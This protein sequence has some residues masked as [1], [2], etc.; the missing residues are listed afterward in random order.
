MRI[1]PLLLALTLSLA[2]CGGGGSDP[3]A[4]SEQ[5]EQALGSG[6]YAEA[7]KH[8]EGA[9]AALGG[10]SSGDQ[11][12]RA[13]LGLIEANAFIAPERARDDFLDLARTSQDIGPADYAR[14]GGRLNDAKS[15]EIAIEVVDAGIKANP[16][17]PVL[18][19]VLEQIEAEARRSGNTSVMDK[20]GGLGYLGD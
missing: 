20:L 9:L 5:G 16:E 17:S 18:V 14:I 10:Q 19:K 8:F 1:P 11:Y 3:V 12:L 4:L 7:A 15:P 2:A 6:K 13:R